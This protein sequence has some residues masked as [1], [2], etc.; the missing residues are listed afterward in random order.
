MLYLYIYRASLSHPIHTHTYIYIY[1]YIYAFPS[2]L[3]HHQPTH[4][5]LGHG[6]HELPLQGVHGEG[7]ALLLEAALVDEPV[8][9][10]LLLRLF[11]YVDGWVGV[12]SDV[13]VWCGW[14]LVW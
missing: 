9:Q 2:I 8:R 6:L 3:Y 1:I 11:S 10:V 7:L 13:C 4:L 14:G 12:L 5:V